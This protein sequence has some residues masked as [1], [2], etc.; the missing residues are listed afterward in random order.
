MKKTIPF[1]LALFLSVPALLLCAGASGDVRLAVS[2][3]NVTRAADSV[4]IYTNSGSSTNTNKWGFEVCVDSDGIIIS[5]GGNNSTV[6]LGGFVISAHGKAISPLREA[7]KV[8]FH[9]RYFEKPAAVVISESYI[10]PFFSTEYSF[11]GVNRIRLE[12][13]II[14]YTGKSFTGTNQWGYEVCVDAS[15]FVISLGGNNS[16]I[17]EGGFVVSGHG[18]G[19]ALLRNCMAVGQR[20]SFDAEKLILYVSY[21]IESMILNARWNIEKQIR[22]LDGLEDRFSPGDDLSRERLGAAREEL[23]A[24]I[25]KFRDGLLTENETAE[26]LVGFG[27]RVDSICAVCE[28]SVPFEYR[29]VWVRP[30]EKTREEVRALVA[31]LH[32]L[33]ANMISVE[34]QYSCGTI[35]PMPEDS[36]IQQNPDF[37]GFDVLRAYIEECHALGMEL[38]CWMPVFNLGSATSPNADISVFAKRPDLFCKNQDGGIYDESGGSSMMLDPSDPEAKEFLL[39][40]YEYLITNYDID[41]L[42]LDYIRY[43]GAGAEYDW[44]YC[45]YAAETFKKSHGFYPSFDSKAAWWEDWCRVRCDCVTD[46]VRRVRALIDEKAPGI[47]LSADVFSNLSTTVTSIYQDTETWVNEGLLDLLHPMTYGAATPYAQ[48]PLFASLCAGKCLLAPGIGAYL[49]E[50]SGDVMHDQIDFL[51]GGGYFGAVTFESTAFLEKAVVKK[52][53][54]GV[55]SEPAPSPRLDPEGAAD[56]AYGFFTVRF[57]RARQSGDLT[58]AEHEKLLSSLSAAVRAMKEGDGRSEAAE[59]AKLAASCGSERAKAAFGDRAGMFR[60]AAELAAK[61][62][63]EYAGYIF[64]REKTSPAELGAYLPSGAEFVCGADGKYAGTGDTIEYS[65]GG[66]SYTATVA[67]PGDTNGDGV[68]GPADYAM[69][70][71]ACLGTF[72]LKGDKLEAAKVSG[73]EKLRPA[74]Y[75]MVKRHVLRTYDLY[76]NFG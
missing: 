4:V 50:V 1:I 57:A 12:N 69:I 29:G 10:P 18:E 49:N 76:K 27:K 70:K 75:A 38:H 45:T 37:G 54:D 8:G 14:V 28:E 25:G 6:P 31:R 34:T 55:Y 20:V 41:C 61:R 48:A 53:C 40:F 9:A 74:D 52:I 66:K 58:E 73:G 51:R 59:F 16:A 43:P 11:N 67:V 22:H 68:V 13:Q 42:Q 64:V 26:Y 60:F 3:F 33:G 24:E 30:R 35:F 23:E 56:A 46:L 7:A 15:G 39:G 19:A 71:R 63:C 36:L 65:A 72:T 21:D 44:G 32:E 62:R 47:M 5:A 2:G 17:P